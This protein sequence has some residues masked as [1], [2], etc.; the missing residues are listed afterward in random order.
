MQVGNCTTPAQYFHLLRRQMYGGHDRRGTRKPLVIFT[1]KSLLR[2]PAAVSHVHE[3]TAGGFIG[4]S[5]PTTPSPLDRPRRDLPRGLLL[6]QD[7][8]DLLAARRD[9][10]PITSRWCASSSSIPSPP[11]RPRDILA[12][13]PAAAE[14]VW[15][16]EEP[17]NMG[18]WRFMREA[19]QPL[20]DATAPRTPLLGR[21]ESA[22][23][24]D[25]SGKRHQQ[26]QAEIVDG[27]PTKP[28]PPKPPDCA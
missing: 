5:A 11:I 14:V 17:R 2:H 9:A 8:Y 27:C 19:I 23:P 25:G 22:S 13:Y 7:L 24:A 28:P 12:C 6:R 18:P 1:P 21:P 26:E 15:A 10:K 3:F 4:D 16:Q 20:L